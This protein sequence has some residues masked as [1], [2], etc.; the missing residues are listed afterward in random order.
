MNP[1]L[2]GLLAGCAVWV[3]ASV[4]AVVGLVA[5]ARRAEKAE[6]GRRHPSGQQMPPGMR[7]WLHEVIAEVEAERIDEE[8]ARICE[9]TDG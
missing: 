6:C 5:A 8:W 3:G 4:V 2:A 1:W 7:E 9:A